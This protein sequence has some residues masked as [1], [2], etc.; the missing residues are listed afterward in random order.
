MGYDNTCGRLR[1]SVNQNGAE[2]HGYGHGCEVACRAGWNDSCE[3]V[4]LTMS[5]EEMRDLRHLI[6]RAIAAADAARL[7]SSSINRA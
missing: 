6:D 3:M 1:V 2:Q 5:V 4:A 7:A